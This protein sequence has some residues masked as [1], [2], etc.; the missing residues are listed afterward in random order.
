MNRRIVIFIVT[1]CI[2]GVGYFIADGMIVK[3]VRSD[4]EHVIF[5]DANELARDSD[6]IIEIT[7]TNQYENIVINDGG[8]VDGRTDTKVK[9]SK[10]I[11]GNESSLK[12]HEYF[13]VTEPYFVLDNGVKPGETVY[14]YGDY[15]PLQEESKYILFLAYSEG[16]D[17]YWVN[18]LSQ[19]KYNIDETD[20]I[21]NQ[22]MKMNDQYIDLKMD[23]LSTF[24][25]D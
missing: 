9:V 14:Y 10:V 2:V 8:Y 15:T 25:V 22:I 4:V 12:E 23:V 24:D 19:G 17:S 1:L 6:L 11:K 16:T 7:A 5:E 20:D 13:T 3:E 18:S 21:E